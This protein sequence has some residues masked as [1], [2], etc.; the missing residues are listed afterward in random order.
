[1]PETLSQ[2]KVGD[3]VKVAA[4]GREGILIT[5]D[6]K[7]RCKVALGEKVVS[8]SISQLK[9]AKPEIAKKK[10]PQQPIEKRPSMR[11][12]SPLIIDLHGLTT[13]EAV[14]QVEM[15]INRA[16][17]DGHDEVQIIHGIGSGKVRE[18]V[19]SYLKTVELVK[20]YQLDPKNRGKTRVFI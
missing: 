1:M 18:A 10:T 6:K 9:L 3:R 16:A 19:T 7:G 17:L 8:C 14:Y 12:M 5:F 4:L 11:I 2:F 13:V 15:A 20:R